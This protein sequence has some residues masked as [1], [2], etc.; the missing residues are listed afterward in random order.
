MKE[1]LGSHVKEQILLYLGLRGGTSGRRLA[2]VLKMSPT[3]VFKALHQLV[4]HGVVSKSGPPYFYALNQD[5]IYFDEL[6]QMIFK[7]YEALNKKPAYSRALPRE[8]QIDPIAIYRFLPVLG[9]ASKSV[10]LSEALRK[11]HA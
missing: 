4:R 2:R 10:S 9:K 7:K 5:Y 6:I 1:L 11:W 3:P 8:R